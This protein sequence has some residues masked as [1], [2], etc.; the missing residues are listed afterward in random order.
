MGSSILGNMG[1]IMANP[2][3]TRANEK[4]SKR[5]SKKA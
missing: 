1:N 5:E 4:P 2:D 3:P